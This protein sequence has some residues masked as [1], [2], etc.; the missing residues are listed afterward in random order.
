MIQGS[1]QAQSMCEKEFIHPFI[2][3]V[4]AGNEERSKDINK[5][6]AT[7]CVN[8]KKRKKPSLPCHY[9]D[10]RFTGIRELKK[11]GLTDHI[12]ALDSAKLQ[13]PE[14]IFPL[15]LSS[16]KGAEVRV[17]PMW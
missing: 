17:C 3:K 5:A 11:H 14:S 8:P 4:L 10:K 7:V 15:K 16:Y 13:A 1:V 12:V 6:V 2:K 9:C